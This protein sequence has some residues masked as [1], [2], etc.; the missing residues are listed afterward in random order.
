MILIMR[1]DKCN[2]LN[3]NVNGEVVRS[4][5]VC[6]CSCHNIPAD[7]DAQQGARVGVPWACDECNHFPNSV[8]SDTC[9]NCGV[10]RH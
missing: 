7:V 9:E 2:H 4:N 5:V 10:P 8:K 6:E 3:G 1:C